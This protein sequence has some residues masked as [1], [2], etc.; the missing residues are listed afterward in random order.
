L[1]EGNLVYFILFSLKKRVNRKMNGEVKN[2]TAENLVEGT[3][4]SRVE[5]TLKAR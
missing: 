5:L 3:Q 2:A 1:G 4:G